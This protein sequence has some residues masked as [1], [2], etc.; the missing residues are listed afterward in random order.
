M[1]VRSDGIGPAIFGDERSRQVCGRPTQPGWS[2]NRTNRAPTRPGS[3]GRPR[4]GGNPTPRNV[5]PSGGTVHTLLIAP[6]ATV[7][8]ASF[9]GKLQVFHRGSGAQASRQPLPDD[10][11]V[12]KS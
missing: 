7:L 8:Y 5:T 9:D 6:S 4:T 2:G 12:P 11:G 1:M 3:R 10:A